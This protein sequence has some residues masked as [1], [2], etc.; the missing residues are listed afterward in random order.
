MVE[1]LS[2][3]HSSSPIASGSGASAACCFESFKSRLPSDLMYLSRFD[4]SLLLASIS[5]SIF[6]REKNNGFDGTLIVGKIRIYC[7]LPVLPCLSLLV[8][9]I[10]GL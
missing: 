9:I 3:S 8:M 6:F 10:F 5:S 1:L 4:P 2:K 7:L